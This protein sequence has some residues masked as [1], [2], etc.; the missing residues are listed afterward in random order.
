MFAL[1]ALMNIRACPTQYGLGALV[2]TSRPNEIFDR[3]GPAVAR[4]SALVSVFF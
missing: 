4:M 1:G 3:F 2:G